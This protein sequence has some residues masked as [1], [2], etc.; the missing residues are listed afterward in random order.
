MDR[1]DA[2]ASPYVLRDGEGALVG[3]LRF[4][5]LEALASALEALRPF[6]LNF[7]LEQAPLAALSYTPRLMLRAD[8]RGGGS[9]GLL[10]NRCFADA[11]EQG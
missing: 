10:F 8:W 11:L 3:T 7:L 9:L 6:A 4:K 1:F 5:R 2:S